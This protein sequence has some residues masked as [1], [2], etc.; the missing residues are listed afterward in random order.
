M[1]TFREFIKEGNPLARHH[2]FEQ[3]G[4]SYVA[5]SAERTRYSPERNARRMDNME[6]R[7]KKMGYGYRKTEGRWKGGKENSFVVY[8]KGTEAKHSD[9][10]L[11]HMKALGTHYN[12]DSILHHDGKTG[13]LHAT[14]HNRDFRIGEK[15][16]IGVQHFNQPNDYGI[17]KFKRNRSKAA[18]KHNDPLTY[19]QPSVTMKD[20]PRPTNKRGGGLP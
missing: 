9:Q 4:R 16:G 17:T 19:H 18:E 15:M 20:N 2:K 8:A 14:N 11:N 5:I 13:K 12:Q 3:E 7:L 6:K 1:Q 10:L